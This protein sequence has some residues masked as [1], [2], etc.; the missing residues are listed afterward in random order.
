[1][2]NKLFTD[3]AFGTWDRLSEPSTYA[4]AGGTLAVLAFFSENQSFLE[5]LGQ[6]PMVALCLAC[7]ALGVGLKEN[8]SSPKKD[9][10]EQ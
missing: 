5:Y 9:T 4:S 10:D 2:I 6:N 3:L 7:F 8:K 1:M